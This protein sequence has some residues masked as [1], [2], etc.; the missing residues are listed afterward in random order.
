MADQ[1][2][3]QEKLVRYQILEGRVKALLQRREM[4]I[5]KIIEVENTLTSMGE[6]EKEKESEILLPLGS[7]VHIPGILK[8]VKKMIV[9]IGA[10][11]ALEKDIVDA[12][13]ILGERKDIMNNG[14][15]SIEKEITNITNEML[16]I[17]QE[18]ASLMGRAKNT[19]TSAG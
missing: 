8:D 1:K 2:E 11:V 16:G 13:K 5:A 18:I 19:D 12:K 3:F 15:Q 14:L 9:E 7:N 4:L 17:E 6:I 10:D